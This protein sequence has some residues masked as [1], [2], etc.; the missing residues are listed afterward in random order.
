MAMYDWTKVYWDD[1]IYQLKQLDDLEDD[2]HFYAMISAVRE[3]RNAWVDAK[4]VYIGQAYQQHV[5]TRIKQNHS[6]YSKLI[7][8]QAVH[9]ERDL[10]VMIGWLPEDEYSAQRITQQFVD[11]IEALLIFTNQPRFNS[12]HKASYAGRHLLVANEGEFSPL[13]E[14]SACCTDHLTDWRRDPE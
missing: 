10:L 8:Y 14:R 7:Q 1:D 3:S 13:K 12:K 5:R 4:L 9:K 6:S 11:D 2:G